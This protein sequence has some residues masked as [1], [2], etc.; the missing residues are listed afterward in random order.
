MVR[1]DNQDQRERCNHVERDE[2]LA[3]MIAEIG[4]NRCRNRHLSRGADENGVAIRGLMGSKVSGDATTGTN[5]VFDDRG[6]ARILLKLLHHKPREQVI[7]AA[8][9]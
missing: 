1:G 3:G 7:T 5:L 6:G 2:A 8:S 4:N 9:G